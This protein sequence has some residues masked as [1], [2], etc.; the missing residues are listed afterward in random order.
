KYDQEPSLEWG[1]V[2]DALSVQETYFWRE[3]EQMQVLSEVLLPALTV[4]PGRGPVRI[5]SVPCATGEEALT[6]AM[7]LN[8]AGW[9]ERA[10]IEIYGSDASPR[11]IEKARRG[12]YRE[13]SFRNLSPGLRARYFSEEEEGWRVRADLHAR[14]HWTVTNLV[15]RREVA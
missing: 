11:A 15:D 12:L 10:K 14:I 5:W 1:L 7:V 9:F 2:M 6:I 4:K 3:I 8:E 13:R